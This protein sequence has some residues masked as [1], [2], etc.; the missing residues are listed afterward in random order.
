LWAGWLWGREST[1]AFKLVLRRRRYD[2]GWH[3]EALGAALSH[4]FELVKLGTPVLSLV[5]EPEPAFLTAALA[6]GDINGYHLQ[7]LAMRTQHDAAQIVWTRGDRLHHESG[8]PDVS[9]VRAA[10]RAHLTARGEPTF[11]LPLHA[12]GL[13][14]LTESHALTRP[15]QAADEVIK[16]AATVIQE[17]LLGDE[18]L[19][20]YRPG[21]SV[22]TG[23]W[24][25]ADLSPH[26]EPLTDRVEMAVVSFVIEHPDCTLLELQRGLAARFPGLLTPSIRL[27]G[28][29]LVSYAEFANGRWRLRAEDAPAA[30]KK[31]LAQLGDLIESI[32]ERL[33]FGTNRLDARTLVWESGETSEYVFHLKASAVIGRAVAESPYPRE[34]SLVVIPGGRSSLLAYKQGRD[35]AL[36]ARLEGFRFVKFR[37]IRALAEIP[38]LN[39]QTFEEQITRDPVEQPRGQLRMF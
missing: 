23:L 15:R 8:T 13:T 19:V 18:T 10:I 9:A 3:L 27:V 31:E 22:D 34:R 1:E 6:A 30:R 36:A 20:R 39:R 35:P 11:Y 12:A 37:L 29:V 38:V 25:N 21:E 26:S 24:G 16:S 14:A 7:S 2:W 17:A 4:L 32:G 5:P 33:E 28:E